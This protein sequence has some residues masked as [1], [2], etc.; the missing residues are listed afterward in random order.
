MLEAIFHK[1]EESF[2]AIDVLYKHTN[3]PIHPALA[4][5]ADKKVIHKAVC[6]PEDI[7]Y[8]VMNI[9]EEKDYV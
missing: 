3:V 9:L 5:I 4:G 2:K 8:E 1:E 6:K 7:C